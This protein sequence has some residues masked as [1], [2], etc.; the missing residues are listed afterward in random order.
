MSLGEG[1]RG[2]MKKHKSVSSRWSDMLYQPLYAASAASCLI[3]LPAR[4]YLAALMSCLQAESNE[5]AAI[6]QVLPPL[7]VII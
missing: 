2:D 7:G 1:I 3:S 5:R 4:R 6:L